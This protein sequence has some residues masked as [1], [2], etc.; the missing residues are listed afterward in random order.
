MRNPLFVPESIRTSDLFTLMKRQQTHMVIVVDEYGGVAGIVTMEDIL[1][2]IVGEIQ[3]EYDTET[4]DIQAQEDGA[5]LVS[6]QTD[7]EELSEILGYSFES[8]DAESIGGLVLSISGEFPENGE[9]FK[10]GP[11]RIEVLE[12]EDHRIM[13]L[14]LCREQ[15]EEAN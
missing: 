7:L 9:V 14:R 4:P 8:D 6:G 2:E 5:W 1:E 11:W 10:Y 12:V 15:Q 3:D 13:S